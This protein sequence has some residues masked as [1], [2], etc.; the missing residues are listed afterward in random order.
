[1]SGANQIPLP[2][3]RRLTALAQAAN[4]RLS[5]MPV[6][7]SR[8]RGYEVVRN[9]PDQPALIFTTTDATFVDQLPNPEP[10][11]RYEVRTLFVPHGAS[12][13]VTILKKK[14][15]GLDLL[16]IGTK[17][18]TVKAMLADSR[19]VAQLQQTYQKDLG[20]IETFIIGIGVRRARTGQRQNVD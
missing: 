12:P 17:K 1:M 7:S 14:E 9:T 4:V 8:V 16:S 15:D 18:E 20:A 5:W 10:S 11:V 6:S 19:A 2:P 13:L 3:V